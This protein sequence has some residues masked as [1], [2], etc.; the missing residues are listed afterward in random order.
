MGAVSDFICII[1]LA[2]GAL[3]F[4]Y[5]VSPGQLRATGDDA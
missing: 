5:L 1:G 2:L 4:L 3:Y